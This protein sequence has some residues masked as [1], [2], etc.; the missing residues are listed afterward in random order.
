MNTTLVTFGWLC[1][2]LSMSS[3]VMSFYFTNKYIFYTLSLFLLIIG[4]IL[5]TNYT[6]HSSNNSI[7]SNT[8]P[9]SVI[10]SEGNTTASVSFSTIPDAT[11]Y[12][13]TS[14]PGNRV[15]TGTNS[16]IIVT[17]LVNDIQYSFTVTASTSTGKKVKSL[18]SNTIKPIRF[19]KAPASIKVQAEDSTAIVSF[20]RI[21]NSS[22]TSFTVIA[23]P[24]GMKA[25]G[26]SSPII[27]KGLTN[28]TLYTFTV[29]S[30]D[31][32]D[33]FETSKPTE[34]IMITPS[35]PTVTNVV[36]IP[37]HNSVLVSFTT[38]ENTDDTTEKSKISN[39]SD[40]FEPSN[41]SNTFE[42]SKTSDPLIYTVTS[43][44]SGIKA[45]GDKSPILVTGLKNGTSYT[46]IVT[47]SNKYTSSS[48]SKESSPITPIPPP[49]APLDAYVL[50][51]GG[52]EA[53]ISFTSRYPLGSDINYTVTSSPGNISETSVMDTIL[54][55]GLTIGQGYTFTV[56]ANN[57][58]GPSVPSKPTKEIIM[59]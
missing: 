5:L 32:I 54:V 20:E 13:V 59:N 50:S 16:P 52:G 41:P 29:T 22:A 8:I 4:F 40:T 34:P 39:I 42:K 36:S 57:S 2:V 31:D 56:T 55:S 46:F 30:M 11:L 58:A 43:I 7:S 21:D 37:K 12:T 28:G 48:P 6:M 1:I 10:A 18:P 45:T 26:T 44:P 47:A 17:G 27:V 51:Y 49:L 14:N 23:S 15:A 3:F 35:L 9:N 24:G 25:T 53:Y 38:F 33:Q 19:P